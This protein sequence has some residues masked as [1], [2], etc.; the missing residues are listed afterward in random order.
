MRNIKIR[1]L[2]IYGT[3]SMIRLRV[4]MMKVKKIKRRCYWR[5]QID[6]KNMLSY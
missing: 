3:T 5:L 1:F 4:L 2:K 6:L